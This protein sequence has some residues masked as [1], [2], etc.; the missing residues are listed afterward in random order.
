MITKVQPWG[1]SQGLRLNKQLLADAGIEVGDEV[2]A[3]IQDGSIVVTP[4]KK[5]RGKYKLEDLV[6]Q[7]PSEYKAAE[8][9]WGKPSGKE[10]W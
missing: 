8:T 10:V 5:E 4:I 6:K 9:Q 3:T 2:D 1:N 7:I